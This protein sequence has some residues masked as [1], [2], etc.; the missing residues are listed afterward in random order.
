MKSDTANLAS[1]VILT[2]IELKIE[3]TERL[4][5]LNTSSY[6]LLLIAFI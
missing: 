6:N 4:D 5:G 2:A 1:K 3:N